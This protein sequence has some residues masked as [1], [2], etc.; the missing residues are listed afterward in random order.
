M[1]NQIQ[2]MAE[3]A[4]VQLDLVRDDWL[5]RSGVT[6]VD[7]GFIWDGAVMTDQVGIR[8]KVEKLLE[9]SD[10]PEGELFP[11][12][13]TGVRVQ[14]REERPLGPQISP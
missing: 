12:Y 4:A 14:V 6:G 1:D 10:V 5:G 7:V 8:V 9:P 11:R 2:A 13:L 3:Q